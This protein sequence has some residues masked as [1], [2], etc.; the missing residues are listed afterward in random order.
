MSAGGGEQ[1]LMDAIRRMEQCP[2]ARLRTLLAGVIRH[3]HDFVREY[4][5]SEA[6]WRAAIRFLT[7]TGQICS[8]ARQEFILLSDVLG[9]S[10]VVDAINHGYRAAR[11]PHAWH[12]PSRRGRTLLL[13]NGYPRQLPDSR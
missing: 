11:G 1:I 2:D 8:D 7:R 13:A 10:M 5:V 4:R 3:L 12:V 9:V 6:E